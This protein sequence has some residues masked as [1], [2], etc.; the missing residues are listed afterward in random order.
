[1]IWRAVDVPLPERIA[2]G[3]GS[4]GDPEH[5][6][7]H[8]VIEQSNFRPRLIGVRNELQLDDPRSLVVG[9]ATLMWFDRLVGQ[10]LGV[11][12]AI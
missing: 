6:V 10:Y 9:V 5:A 7:F 3:N 1:M 4:K 2:G 8:A 11:L 12:D